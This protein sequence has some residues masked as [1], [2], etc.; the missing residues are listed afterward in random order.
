MSDRKVLVLEA[1]KTAAYAL[2]RALGR[3]G[4]KI[5]A[6]SHLRINPSFSS[7]YVSEKKR[8]P[9]IEDNYDAYF[10]WLSAE[11]SRTR[12]LTVMSFSDKT[13][14]LLSQRKETLSAYT[15]IYQ[16][17]IGITEKVLD[18]SKTY[19]AARI[20][21]LELPRVYPWSPADKAESIAERLD[22]PVVLKPLQKIII[23]NGKAFFTKVNET[24][25]VWKQREFKEK[26]SRLLGITDRFEIQQYIEGAGRGYF[27]ILWNGKPVMQFAHE[28][29]REYPVRGGASSFRKSI[30]YA[31]MEPLS[32]K[33]LN[34]IQWSGPA[35]VEYKYD[36]WQKK[37][38]LMEVNGRWWGSLPLALN[39]GVNFPLILL[40]LIERGNASG[41][42]QVSYPL[43]FTSRLLF[44]HDVMWLSSQLL[45][46]RFSRALGFFKPAD[47]EDLFDRH[48]MKPFFANIVSSLLN[49]FSKG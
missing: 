26:F 31:E 35:M 28:R 4:Y 37:Y 19:E 46:L 40:R 42:Q 15:H 11:V 5:T 44:P 13:T 17:H 49:Y 1:E 24:N 27:T 34:Q 30:D 33:L 45:R 9:N 20:A 39:A 6:C 43:N 41:F 2:C 14:R 25:Y 3:E 21:G 12:Y 29:I 48:D 32:V 36:P 16:P 22:Y 7:K 10:E 23:K 8:C 18:K 47:S 38:Y